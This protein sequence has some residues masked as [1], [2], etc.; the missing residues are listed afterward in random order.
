M[1]WG[2]RRERVFLLILPSS[3]QTV[4]ITGYRW[5]MSKVAQKRAIANYRSRLRKKGLARFEVLGLA[6]DRDLI[7]SL[8][9]K[10]AQGDQEANRI[11]SE[12]VQT[13]AP[14]KGGIL[15]ALRRS[16]LVGA[17]LVLERPL[18]AGREVDL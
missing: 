2:P 15:A 14:L 16:P 8:A 13:V 4:Y 11:R 7:R 6:S 12:V 17:D 9:K 5:I 18:E 1:R 10:L 3:K